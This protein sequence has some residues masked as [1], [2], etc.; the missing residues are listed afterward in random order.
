MEWT[1]ESMPDEEPP[2]SSDPRSYIRAGLLIVALLFGGLG[3]W[4]S[5]APLHGAVIAPGVVT[6]ISKRKTVQHLDGGIAREILVEDGDAVAQGDLLIRLDD[7]QTRAALA[8]AEAQLDVLRAREARLVAE[9]DEADEIVLSEYLAGRGD[10]AQVAEILESQR[11]LFAARRTSLQ[12]EIEILSQRIGQL[13]DEVRGLEAQR[14]SKQRQIELIEEELAGLHELFER[15][16]ASRNRMRELE[17]E[18][19]ELAGELGEHVADIAR[20]RNGIGEAKLRVFQLRK[21]FRESVVAELH[22]V[23]SEIF[24]ASERR[25]AALDR[26]RRLEIRSPRAGRV[27]AKSVHTVGA[28]IAPGEPILQIVPEDDE[29]VVEAKV[30]PSDIDRVSVGQPARVR[31][32]AFDLRTTPE[33][34]GEVIHVSA[35][36]VG[37]SREGAP[38]YLIRTRIPP[39]QLARLGELRLIPGMPAETFI[40]TGART[41]MAYLL[42]PLRD[43]LART[44]RDA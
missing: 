19:A 42:K 1:S 4:A 40:Q 36:R 43:G 8:I 24:D 7:T 18:A 30:Q 35:D 12:G 28:V 31:L 13:G 6:V 5:L 34:E 44:F 39:E 25:V 27:V 17:R 29:L 23:R 32:S 26:F 11:Q 14:S 22:D 20:A 3:T 15:G 2:I 37:D 38:H 41:V 10:D 33:L 21:D 16:F 9:R